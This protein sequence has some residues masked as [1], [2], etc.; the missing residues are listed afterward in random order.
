MTRAYPDAPPTWFRLS[1]ESWAEIRE[2]YR[3]GATARE[4]AARWRVSPTSIY[5]HACVG[6]WTKKASADAL[7]RAHANDINA[8]EAADQAGPPQPA[9][10]A[11]EATPLAMRERAM[12]ELARALAAGR[13]RE[14]QTLA[15]LVES[16]ERLAETE[17]EPPAEATTEPEPYTPG[18]MEGI[19]YLKERIAEARAEA[20]WPRMQRMAE[21]LLK[22]HPSVPTVFMR[23]ALRWRARTLG[24]EAAEADRARYQGTAH[25]SRYYDEQGAIR[26]GWGVYTDGKAPPPDVDPQFLEDLDRA[27]ALVLAEG[28]DEDEA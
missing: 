28:A 25:Y 19:K 10:S 11:V 21:T 8:E 14:A 15:K 24:P 18:S 7:A 27:R 2:A 3:N 20:A 1:E 6:G 22:E 5:R 4:L 16:L 17:P 26:E 12:S 13:Y 9:P 23:G